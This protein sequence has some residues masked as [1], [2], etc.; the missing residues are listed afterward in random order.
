MIPL[1]S[2][3]WTIHTSLCYL[4]IWI[5][6]K[7]L[8]M[9]SSSYSVLYH[10]YTLCLFVLPPCKFVT[11]RTQGGM[12]TVVQKYRCK[13]WPATQ[14]N[15]RIENDMKHFSATMQ[16]ITQSYSLVICFPGNSCSATLW[17]P[18]L[19]GRCLQEKLCSTW[20]NLARS[21]T[22]IHCSSENAWSIHRGQHRKHF[23]GE[24]LSY[25]SSW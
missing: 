4:K 22:R 1:P 5:W 3:L 12:E 14:W 9:D 23:Y 13:V 6:E 2:S 8:V 16:S 19:S 25:R 7:V 24:P 20:R 21:S 10:I 11:C 17:C 18:M 15:K